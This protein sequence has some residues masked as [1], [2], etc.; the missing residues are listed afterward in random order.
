MRALL[1]LLVLLAGQS[2]LLP[3]VDDA[4]VQRAKEAEASRPDAPTGTRGEQI[5]AP[6]VEL[7]VPLNGKNT[8]LRR[9]FV[10]NC[11]HDPVVRAAGQHLNFRAGL[12][13]GPY[14]HG[15]DVATPHAG[16]RPRP[17]AC[18]LPQA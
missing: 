6:V 10:A 14:T 4:A 17:T 2:R 1:V 12:R 13:H 5:I 3:T 11:F 8:P 7:G 18:S 9:S 15:V 16:R